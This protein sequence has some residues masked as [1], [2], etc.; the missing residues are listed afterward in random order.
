MEEIRTEDY[1]IAYDT[2]SATMTFEGSLRLQGMAEYAPIS[3]ALDTLAE[4]K[5]AAIT[6]NL[7]ALKFLNS[8]GIN[9]LSKFVIKMRKQGDVQLVIKGTQQYPWQGKS[10]KN[11]ER[12]MPGLHLEFE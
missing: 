12:L 9:M 1:C 11:L 2:E 5:P 4:Q 10:L 7:Q 6:L 3:Q 8:S